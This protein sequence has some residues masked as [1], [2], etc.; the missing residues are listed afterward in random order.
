[1]PWKVSVK[2]KDMTLQARR[3]YYSPKHAPDDASQAKE[4]MRE[5]FF[6]RD[7]M[8]EIPVAMQ[9][10]FFKVTPE[11]AKVSGAYARSTSGRCTSAEPTDET[12]TR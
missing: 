11:S 6:S 8:V 4:E 10:Q 7:E 3:G 1:M 2:A 9:T 12:L 5:A